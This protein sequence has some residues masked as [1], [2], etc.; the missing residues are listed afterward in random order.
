MM[1]Q[2]SDQQLGPSIVVDNLSKR[3]GSFSALEGVSFTVGRG[4]IMGFL[5]PNGAGKSTLIRVLCGLLRPTS[6]RAVVAGIDIT[7]DPE[8][9][10]RRIGYMSQ[11]FSLY[12]DLSVV[13]NLRFF[14]G[15]YGVSADTIAQ[16][17]EFAIEMAGLAGRADALVA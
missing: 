4:E 8:A 14:G 7:V 12:S 15:I 5:G 13:E 17:V 3:F 2:D 1:D 16:R 11:K 6:G 9:V 10:R